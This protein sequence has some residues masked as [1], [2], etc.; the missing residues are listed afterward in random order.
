MQVES[1]LYS[2][3][4]RMRGARRL[5]ISALCLGT[6]L[7]AAVSKSHGQAF[8]VTNILSDGSVSAQATDASFINPWGVSASPNWWISAQGSGLN[9]VLPV[10]GTPAFKVIV[11]LAAQPTMNGLPSGSVTTSGSTGFLLPNGSAPSFFFSTLDGTISG[12]N[13]KLGTNGSVAQLVVNNQGGGAAYTGLAL[14]NTSTASFLLA[15]HFSSGSVEVYNA[16]YQPAK[17]AGSF[18]DPNL[19]TGYFPFS[20]H[21]LGTQIFVAYAQHSG[22]VAPY[23]ELV[24]LG[25]GVVDVFD[26]TGNFVSR[27]VTGGNLNAPWGVAYAPANFGIY[28]NDL[29]IGNFG[30]GKIN[31]YGPK[32]FS[33]V[34]QLM[35][36]SGKSL[37]YASLWELLTGGTTV[38]GTTLVSGGSISN[39]YFSAGLVGE[40]HGLFASIS[41]STVA[42]SAPTFGFSSASSAMTVAAGS[43]ATVGLSVAPVNG[44]SGTVSLSCTGLPTGATCNFS[45]NQ[46][47]VAASAASL[48]TVTIT[49]TAASAQLKHPVIGKEGALGTTLTIL[50]PFGWILGYRRRLRANFHSMTGFIGVMP[51]IAL[52]GIVSL[53]GGCSTSSTTPISSTPAGSANVIVSATAGAITQTTT[54]SVTVQ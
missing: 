9:Y 18:T 19:P 6:V 40:A 31:V 1:S 3:Q 29:L 28:S 37:V 47:S 33:Y 25:A 42:G 7:S 45:P 35:D 13:G 44:F 10:S 14:L 48:G 20:I 50:F 11:P 2:S 52:L 4:P 49:T 22:T 5:A 38:S 12:W 15:P 24:A 39:V 17:L 54:I 30:D 23:R 43:A 46:Y 34:G 26:T 8:S 51:C 32:T 27:V 41:N 21:I 16:A 53:L 36:S